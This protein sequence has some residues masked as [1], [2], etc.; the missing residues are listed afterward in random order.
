M[1]FVKESGD[2]E[3]AMAL[4]SLEEIINSAM[5]L[6][7]K[8]GSIEIDIP[9]W[10]QDHIAKSENYITQANQNFHKIEENVDDEVIVDPSLNQNVLTFGLW[11]LKNV[12]TSNLAN[13][14]MSSP[15]P[16][17]AQ[18]MKHAMSREEWMAH[19]SGHGDE[20]GGTDSI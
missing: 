7:D 11:S 5:D 8:I 19:F 18:A 15:D 9:A 13:T 20:S 12:G 1:K 2:H 10:I 17:S 4:S 3:V 16:I 14:Q 6:K